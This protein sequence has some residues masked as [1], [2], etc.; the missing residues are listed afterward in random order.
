MHSTIVI[1]CVC[2]IDGLTT[3]EDIKQ[4]VSTIDYPMQLSRLNKISF[5]FNTMFI[6][7]NMSLWKGCL[8]SYD[9][10]YDKDGAI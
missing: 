10:R 7:L 9:R 1:L 6:L 5:T 2:Y 3:N 8:H 4:R